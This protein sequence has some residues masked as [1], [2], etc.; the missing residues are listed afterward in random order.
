MFKLLKLI[1]DWSEVWA[2]IIPIS[3]L[4]LR[5]KQ[6]GFLKP[7]ILYL[8][9]ALFLNL[10]GDII[11][12]FKSY[13][14][15]WLQS[16]NVLYNIHSLV[17]F[18]CFSYFFRLIG[19]TYRNVLNKI[20]NMVA[21]IFIVYNFIFIEDFFDPNHLSGNLLAT[22]AYLLLV[23]C[24]QYYLSILR[25][26]TEEFYRGKDFWVVTGLSIYV[27]INFFVFL[28]YVPFVKANPGLADKI[29]SI[30]NVAY[31]TLCILIA[32]AFYEPARHQY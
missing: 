1:S 19:K 11:G 3:I 20:I 26:Q 15:G 28:F 16:N 4:Q 22:E 9:V 6:P 32:K 24:M 8:W 27:V 21:L 18:A 25:A 30:H 13:L 14:P 2:L 10:S 12:D 31:I 23:Y 17:R 29:W 7:V 5:R